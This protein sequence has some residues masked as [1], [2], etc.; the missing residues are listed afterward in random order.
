MKLKE[1]TEN[2]QSSIVT[3]K[4]GNSDSAKLYVSGIRDAI[5]RGK[6]EFIMLFDHLLNTTEGSEYAKLYSTI[7]YKYFNTL[8]Q[9]DNQTRLKVLAKMYDTLKQA[10]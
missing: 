7:Y 5:G 8:P 2:A 9:D 1:L 3:F 6:T 10:I 4:N